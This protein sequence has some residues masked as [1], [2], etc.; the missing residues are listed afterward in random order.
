MLKPVVEG[1]ESEGDPVQIH[2]LFMEGKVVEHNITNPRSALMRMVL[3]AWQ[4]LYENIYVVC[5]GPSCD[6]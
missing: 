2:L 3:H 1:Q 4:H 5:F 6:S